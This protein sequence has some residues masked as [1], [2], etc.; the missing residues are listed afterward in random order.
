MRI[1]SVTLKNYRRHQHLAVTL[2]A[3]RLLIHGP[4]EIGKS[5]LIEAIHRCLFYRHRSRAAG[6]LERMQPRTGGDPEVTLEFS[7]GDRR[8]TL[9]KKFRGA[10]GSW[11]FLS[12]DAGGQ[13][14]GDAA[15]EDLQRLL[16]VEEAR[17]QQVEVF[18]SRWAHLWVWQGSARDE[19]SGTTCSST[20]QQLRQQLQ[21]QGGLGVIASQHDEAVK[22][23]LIRRA[24]EIFTA[25]GRPRQNSPL[26]Q[27][28]TR[29]TAAQEKLQT[30][31]RQWQAG[32]EAAESLA[33]AEKTIT[34]QARRKAE[35]EA[36]LGPLRLQLA[37]ASRLRETRDEQQRLAEQAAARLADVT[38]IENEISQLVADSQALAHQIKPAE[39]QLAQT[40]QQLGQRASETGSA[41]EALEQSRLSFARAQ[42]HR[43]LYA[44]QRIAIQTARQADELATVIRR[45]EAA[46]QQREALER[47]LD[48][49]PAIDTV[50]VEEL[51]Q[52]EQRAT[53]ARLT[54]QLLA[55]R[56]E[57]AAGGH[58]VRIDE[59]P[60]PVGESR[61]ITDQTTLTIDGT[62][63]LLIA[64]GG[65]T[66]LA[67]ARQ[68]SDKAADLFR[69]R[70]NE[71]GVTDIAAASERLATRQRLSQQIDQQRDEIAT[72]LGE[73]SEEGLLNRAQ[74]SRQQLAAARQK[75]VTLQQR[76]G[77]DLATI[78]LPEEL[79]DLDEILQPIEAEYG[80]LQQTVA[81]QSA[82]QQAAMQRQEAAEQTVLEQQQTVEAGR[83][84]LDALRLEQRLLEQQHGDE[85]A[86]AADLA[87]AREAQETAG[88]SLAATSDVLERFD[89]T[90]LESDIDRYERSIDQ[91]NESIQAARED[92]AA[93]KERLQHYGALDLHQTR[94]TAQAEHDLA[95]REHQQ[96]VKQASAIARLR[97]C[98]VQLSSDRSDQLAAPL[99]AKAEDYLAAMFGKGT[100][101]SL[102]LADDGE[103][104]SDLRVTRPGVASNSFSFSELS[105]GTQEQVA[106]AMRLAMAEILAGGS[107]GCL[108]I[109]FDDAFTNSDPE[110]IGMLQ[111][112]LD[113]AATR[114]LQVIVLSCNP[115][116]YHMFGATEIDLQR[117]T[118]QLLPAPAGSTAATLSAAMATGSCAE[119]D[120]AANRTT[121]PADA[122]DP[123]STAADEE[124]FL[125]AVRRAGG[126]AGNNTLR[127]QLGWDE[128]RYEAVK[129]RLVARGTIEK[130]RGRGG[131]VKLPANS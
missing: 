67:A 21:Q 14:E 36:A 33:W 60:L 64:P 129:N 127:E 105:G 81:E 58:E 7:I 70:L 115:A 80:Q 24:E 17:G 10:T 114:G 107:G 110:R 122:I 124:Q 96:A 20:S 94:A 55:T 66:S 77:S 18:N 53:Q 104:F 74:A 50:D 99:R 54:V 102:A 83:K 11:A 125:E 56:I 72:R 48:E 41:V 5:S 111:R 97:D 68:E 51:R 90:T 22:A 61:T 23:E 116:D 117:L 82:A 76:E 59:V 71:L 31:E 34:E 100:R 47:Q 26:G 106:A 75:V 113:H 108:P 78:K 63:R 91:A 130:G 95:T 93:A 9:S 8:Y 27:S 16:H 120:A 13:L 121:S 92:R 79:A 32:Q 131:S 101:V 38:A 126:G 35:A 49:I 119:I 1:H 43:D 42:E 123:V 30:A 44:A 19:P 62:T 15:E 46:K 112:M 3:D 103:G 65:G 52:L 40:R 6:L 28:E 57:L 2:D 128:Q 85:K 118:N 39:E 87:A 98:F 88:R 12:D 86:R 89:L 37:E 29:L 84:K 109:V 73:E 25:T 45:I 69:S 4:N